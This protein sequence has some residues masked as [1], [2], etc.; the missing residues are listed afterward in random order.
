MNAKRSFYS[1]LY[2]RQQTNQNSVEAKR[3]QE[4]PG[5]S[6]LPEELRASCEGNIITDECEKIRGSLET[7]KTPVNDGIPTKFHKTFWTLI[8]VFMTA[9]SFN[10]AYQC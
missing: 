7:G 2:E 6:K 4:N 9:D 8:G 1:K 3:F 10:E 5:I